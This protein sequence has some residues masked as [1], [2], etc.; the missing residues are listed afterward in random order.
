MPLKIFVIPNNDNS[1]Y[2]C[3]WLFAKS[4]SSAASYDSVITWSSKCSIVACCEQ[5]VGREEVVPGSY[6]SGI[7]R[8]LFFLM[9]S[10]G[11]LLLKAKWKMLVRGQAF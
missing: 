1:D 2:S 10:Q 6:H 4:L 9:L 3:A 8:C 7:G 5:P 11:P